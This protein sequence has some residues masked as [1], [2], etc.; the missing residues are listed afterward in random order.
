MKVSFKLDVAKHKAVK[1]INDDSLASH[2]KENI[3][4]I[5]EHL[6][7]SESYAISKATDKRNEEPNGVVRFNSLDRGVNRPLVR[8]I[9]F[10]DAMTGIVNAVDSVIDVNDRTSDLSVGANKMDADFAGNTMPSS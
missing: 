8:S 4:F 2:G 3:G 1:P 5:F 7:G 10:G 9:A 6:P